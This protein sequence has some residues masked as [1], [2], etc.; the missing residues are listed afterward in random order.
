MADPNVVFRGEGGEEGGALLSPRAVP[1]LSP[2]VTFQTGEE[3]AASLGR[4]RGLRGLPVLSMGAS[5]DF[6]GEGDGS[7]RTL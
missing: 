1:K 6:R 2:F 3:G 7:G 5:A 4:L